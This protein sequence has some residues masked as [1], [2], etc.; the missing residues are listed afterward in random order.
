MIAILLL[1]AADFS[2]ASA[3]EFTRRAVDFGP[4][5]PGSAALGKLRSYMVKELTAA[6]C[7]VSEERFT[8]QTPNGPVAMSNV[9]CRLKGSE[10]KR[11]LVVSGHYDTKFMPGRNFVG[12]N[13][14]GSSTGFLL[15]LARSQAKVKRTRDLWIVFFDGE[16]AFGNWSRTD[17]LYGSRHQADAWER[18][19][20]L[21]R[22]DA[23]I[24]VDMIGDKDLNIQQDLNSSEHLRELVWRTALDLGYYKKQFEASATALEDDHIPFR[25]KGVPAIDIIDF[26]YGVLN[27]YW[28]T[29]QDTMDKLSPTSFEVVGRV[30]TEALR[31]LDQ[32]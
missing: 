20:F 13:D 24:N 26:E 15:E 16:E 3:Y 12:A 31:R 18:S 23:L 14:A 29:E 22:I 28:H 19:G 25:Q 7:E 9:L 8:A 2:G 17:S 10:G 11:V 5:P 1:L 4:R 21:G 6:G 32:K 27:R 30:V